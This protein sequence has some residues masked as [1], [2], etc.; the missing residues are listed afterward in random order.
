MPRSAL[1]CF[2][3]PCFCNPAGIVCY[4]GVLE[5]VGVVSLYR[6]CAQIRL[7]FCCKGVQH[8]VTHCVGIC[9]MSM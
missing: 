9:S 6:I 2:Q 1:L 7:T 4:V 3:T 8:R 5:W